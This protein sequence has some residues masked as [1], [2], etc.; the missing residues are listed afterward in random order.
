MAV[1]HR[2]LKL[3]AKPVLAIK[4]DPVIGQV[5]SLR[6]QANRIVTKPA[7]LVLRVTMQSSELFTETLFTVLRRRLELKALKV[8]VTLAIHDPAVDNFGNANLASRAQLIKPVSLGL[9]HFE[10][11]LRPG[12][13]ECV[14][15]SRLRSAMRSA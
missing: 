15:Q 7:E 5:V 9:E 13:T 8:D 14:S 2:E 3:K 6:C 1:C 12:L 11:R 4:R 10:V